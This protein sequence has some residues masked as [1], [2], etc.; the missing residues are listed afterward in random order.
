MLVI[1]FNPKD[2]CKSRGG[3]P[4]PAQVNTCPMERNMDC[5][6]A[7]KTSRHASVGRHHW[8][9]WSLGVCAQTLPR[10]GAKEIDHSGQASFE[11]Q[12]YVKE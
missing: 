8:G 4:S 11:F 3:I 12:L 9:S 2:Q 5:R 1:L 10:W 6:W 7:K